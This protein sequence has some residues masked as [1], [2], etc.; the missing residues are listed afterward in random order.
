MWVKQKALGKILS[1]SKM[2]TSYNQTQLQPRTHVFLTLT[3]TLKKKKRNDQVD[4][5]VVC[6]HHS[7]FG[8]EGLQIGKVRNLFP[9]CQLLAYSQ[10]PWSSERVFWKALFWLSFRFPLIPGTPC[11]EF[12]YNLER[13]WFSS[14]WKESVW[15]EQINLGQ[16]HSLMLEWLSPTFLGWVL[17]SWETGTEWMGWMDGGGGGRPGA[18]GAGQLRAEE[19]HPPPASHW[20]LVARKQLTDGSIISSGPVGSR[21]QLAWTLVLRPWLTGDLSLPEPWRPVRV[22]SNSSFRLLIYC[23]C[24]PVVDPVFLSVCSQGTSETILQ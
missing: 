5:D 21:H 11:A 13:K 17:R 19:R 4:L 8:G 9:G 24:W 22:Y 2:F 7:S 20:P 16:S 6:S 12:P 1:V 15:P 18:R 3:Q 23:P 14:A 10:I